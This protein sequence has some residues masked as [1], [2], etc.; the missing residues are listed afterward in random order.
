[1]KKLVNFS[2]V[3]VVVGVIVMGC[4]W[5]G[6]GSDGSWSDSYSWIN[7]SGLYRGSGGDVVRDFGAAGPAT[8]GAGNIVVVN[9]ESGG[10]APAASTEL[11]GVLNNRPGI[12]PGSV[13]IVLQPASP[14]GSAGSVTDNGAGGLSG[15]VNL[16][17]I[18]SSTA[19]PVS[20]TI[21]YSTGA[22][23]LTL[24]SPGLLTSAQILANYAYD[25]NIGTGGGGTN[26]GGPSLGVVG[27]RVQSIQIE[28]LGNKLTF[29]TS[30]GH[31][32]EGYL[33][34]VT[35]PG[36]DQTGRSA[37][38]V[39]ATYEV[40][41]VVDGQQVRISGTLSGVYVPP[42]DI[43]F[44]NPQA[45]IIYGIMSNRILQGI[46]MQ[47]NGTADVYGVAPQQSV[48]INVGDLAPIVEDQTEA[49]TPTPTLP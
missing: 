48:P 43:T 20:G 18:D 29:R 6:S 46:W 37:G 4:E 8:P 36:G 42:A 26:G 41:G 39:S 25:A 35:L 14:E 9:N 11:S 30:N 23:T 5:T 49:Q 17:G 28:Q 34:V 47:P 21:N 7:F 32:L 13:T 3:L 45:P 1:M 12:V 15:F 31:V 40:K 33:S 2:I 44:A 16:V 24:Q 38:D 10:T 27:G 22:W 19:N